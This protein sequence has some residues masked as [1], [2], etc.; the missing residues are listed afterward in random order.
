M[1]DRPV[2]A[3]DDDRDVYI[4]RPRTTEK[5]GFFLNRI[6]IQLE[7]IAAADIDRID[8]GLL[9]RL[10]QIREAGRCDSTWHGFIGIELDPDY[11]TA[12]EKRIADAVFNLITK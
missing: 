8:T 11:F 1:V 10:C 12:A 5:V 3:G 7:T 4:R 2:S 6:D 9:D